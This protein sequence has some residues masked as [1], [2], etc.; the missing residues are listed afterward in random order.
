MGYSPETRRAVNTQAVAP[1][2]HEQDLIG[3]GYVIEQGMLAKGTPIIKP[4]DEV[5]PSMYRC[6]KLVPR[7]PFASR[8]GCNPDY[9]S[10]MKMIGTVPKLPFS[11]ESETVKG[12]E[13]RLRAG[14]LSATDLTKEYLARMAVANAAGPALQAVR[15]INPDALSEAAAVDAKLAKRQPVGPLAGIPVLLDDGINAAGLPSTGGS[16]ALQGAMP[17][18]SSTIATK[19]KN[20]GAIIL[21]KANVSELNGLFSSTMPEGYSSLGGQILLPSTPTR[22]RRLLRRRGGRDGLRDGGDVGRDGDLDRHGPADRALCHRRSCRPQAHRR[23]GQPRCGDA[24]REIAGLAGADREDGL[25]RRGRAAGDR[26]SRLQRPGDP[27][28][29]ARGQLPRLTRPRRAG[30]QNG[31]RRRPERR[32]RREPAGLRSRNR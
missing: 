4:V 19:L 32:H 2:Y 24:G 6:A 5:N 16:I 8:G 11:L 12:L 7:P 27:E 21:G 28:R 25:R 29:A 3:I 17:I 14:T 22:T 31:R 9:E 1:A 23:T 18:R 30:G 26:R 13:S 10:V 20:A 15:A